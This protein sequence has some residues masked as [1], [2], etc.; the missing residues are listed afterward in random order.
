MTPAPPSPPPPPD[1]PA[2][3]VLSLAVLSAAALADEVLLTRLFS[4]VQWHHFA[5]MA[6]SIALLGYAASGTFLAL[7]PA[8]ATRS[9][10][11]YPAHIA[12]FAF[13][14]VPAFLL[15]Q[16]L[17]VHPEQL[18][19]A[20]Q[21]LLRVSAVY[22][23]LGLP[24]FFAAN[25]VGL[26]FVRHAARAGTVYAADLLGAGAGALGV[27]GLLYLVFP[28]TALQLVAVA[29]GGAALIA[30]LEL[31]PGRRA[32]LAW[33]LPPLLLAVS[34]AG[35]PPALL[36]LRLSPYKG[37]SQQLAVQGT[38]VLAERSSPLGL[39]TVVANQRVPLRQAP[40]LSLTAPTTVPEQLGVF[41]DGDGLTPI[42]RDGPRETF[43]YLD[44]M[45]S[46]LPY[47]LGH[48]RSVLVLGA[49]GGSLVHQA[50]YH[51]ADAV[52]ALQLDGR[53][54]GLVR[55][56]FGGFAGPVF[57]GAATQ[58]YVGEAR[59]WLASRRERFDLIQLA[60][61]DAFGASSSGLY[62]LSEEYLYTVEALATYYAH[63]EEGGYLA[64]TRWV[65]LP[66]R[67]SLKLF[68][69]AVRALRA[70]G[71][72]DPGDRL[73]VIR[74]WQTS[75]LVVKRGA[76][77]PRELEAA[78]AFCT[79][80]GFDL[81]WYRGMPATLANRFNR[82]PSAQL[83]EGAEALAGDDAAAFLRAYKFDLRPATDD[84][85][86][87]SNFFRWRTLPE[88]LALRGQGGL[89]LLESGYLIVVATLL[90][91][92]LLGGLIVVLPL[93]R[94]IAGASAAGIRPM[95]LV[96]YFAALGLAFLFVEIAFIQKFLLFLHHPVYAVAAVLGGF[97]VFAGLG[98]GLAG[99]YCPPRLYGR[100]TW[101]AIAAVAVLSLLYVWALPRG[102]FEPLLA[103]PL[104]LR[105]AVSLLLIGLIATP[106]GVPFPTGVTR[107]GEAA[108]ALIPLAWA[109][110]GFASVI[111]AVLATL[112]A[113]HFG[114]SA[115]VVLAALLY[116]AAGLSAG[117]VRG[118][119][120]AAPAAAAPAPPP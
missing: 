53:L 102:V 87:F 84:R 7:G 108:P 65:K 25:A 10:W 97:L 110:N 59:G 49:G 29:G 51:R 8:W 74:G 33:S 96:A 105:L 89:P 107:L 16:R 3:P 61:A 5:W 17:A 36:E 81:G 85:P 111:S 120:S 112:L 27:V 109:V 99:R 93:W 32:A 106:M 52:T 76:F 11:A 91:A 64:I 48:P 63:L 30:A 47:H 82:L 42:L 117:F 79:A 50:R 90:Q 77:E 23:L 28:A 100:L 35:A 67:D 78:G 92:V 56:P 104:A 39:L 71:V 41:I 45:T 101:G 1:T 80:R 19:W 57:D 88:V 68:G 95:R 31:R 9:R 46:A 114:F 75:T 115:V 26:A 2:P 13:T 21:Q 103:A 113:T 15:A 62:A 38:T 55:G 94:R 4:I 40:G 70:S 118:G 12:A 43:A 34:F 119:V 20:P 14:V 60:F 37:L 86:Y 72:A 24:F 73:L 22:L 66:L 98:S 18:L 54:T 6:I 69:T 116:L 44:Q 58:L 83:Y